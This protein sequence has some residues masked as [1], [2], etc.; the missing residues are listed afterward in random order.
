MILVVLLIQIALLAFSSNLFGGLGNDI[1]ITCGISLEGL[2]VIMSISQIGLL[3]AFL[4]Y[5]AIIRKFGPYKTMIIGIFGSALG[6]FALGSSRTALMFGM[7]FFLQSLLSYPWNSA[8]FSVISFINR[9]K[10]E[11]NI[12]M[13]HLVYA[14]SSIF[15]GWYISQAKGN[16]WYK[17]Y[18]Q[19]GFAWL[20]MGC[21]FCLLLKKANTNPDLTT[22]QRKGDNLV[23]DGFSL[24]GEKPFCLFYL[25][26]ILA[27]TGESLSMV[28]PLL[29]IQQ[30]LGSSAASVGLA[31]TL[32]HVGMTC[33]R[34][35]LIPCFIKS[36]HVWFIIGLL[37]FIVAA[38]IIFLSLSKTITC[39]LVFLAFSG[40]GFGAL[41]PL[42]QVLEVREWPDRI[43]Q[44][45]NMHSISGTIGKLFIPL[46]IGAVSTH[47]SQAAGIL[48]LGL[49]M[50]LSL[51]SLAWAKKALRV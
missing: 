13:M 26:L 15:A 34:L 22:H 28:Y 45:M 48:T 43:D 14:I 10:R 8:K 32:Y 23:K 3:A 36:K 2:G 16:Q 35:L 25:F 18:F 4:V 40:F 11:R 9:D 42:A 21:M 30:G 6:F 46:F 47:I 38:S 29:F 7:A 41:N 5:P 1:Q 31:I 17:A 49:L 39:A 51:I 33:S 20:F 44:A 12:S 37:D 19:N 24:L 27:T 50:M